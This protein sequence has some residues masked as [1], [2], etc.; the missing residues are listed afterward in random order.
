MSITRRDT[1]EGAHG[2][3]EA[4]L[5]R[6]AAA[7]MRADARLRVAIDDFYLSDAARLDDRTRLAM[8]AV[9]ADLARSIE[10]AV[11]GHAARLLAARGAVPLADA[12]KAE[13]TMLLP[14]LVGAGLVRDP[15]LMRE[16]FGRVRQD[17]LAEALPSEAPDDPDRASLLP[18]LIG[19]SDAVVATRARALLSAESRRRLPTAPDR[20]VSTELPAELHHRLV[21]WIA[22]A[23]RERFAETAG[24]ALAELDRALAE[25]A[26][27]AIAAHDEG[28]RLEAVALRLAAALDPQANEFAGLLVEAL[29]DRRLSLFIALLA[30]ALGLDYGDAREI[31]L[32]PGDERLWLLLRALELDR[33]SIARIGLA[34]S[35]GDPT[36][37]V[38]QFADA[39]DEIV[40][41]APVTARHALAPLLLHRD[42]RAAMVALGRGR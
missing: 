38:D 28:D 13:A 2:G 10:A 42:Y 41:V 37:D 29:A 40:A 4:L 33:D 36:R 31:V 26:M 8:T 35:E 22:A 16:L 1:D 21:W 25:A 17:L 18:R 6:A 34:L 32:D 39:L 20:P 19:A 11:R 9:F 15:E 24:D 3:A 27:R 5:D 30:H 14:R 12:I 7:D 23:L